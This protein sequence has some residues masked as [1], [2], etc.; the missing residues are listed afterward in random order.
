MERSRSIFQETEYLF[1]RAYEEELTE[2]QEEAL[3]DRAHQQIIDYGWDKTFESWKAYLFKNCTTPE[4][5]INFANLFWCYCCCDYIIQDPYHFLGYMY[6]RIDMNTSKY[7]DM[8]ILD[9]IAT[10][11]LPKAGYSCAD[12]MKHPLYTPE[13]DERLLAEVEKFKKEAEEER[14]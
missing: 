12:L 14:L 8:S 9:S 7:D 11:I 6:Y 2:E 3:Y 5:V 1:N 4:S 10:N 13:M